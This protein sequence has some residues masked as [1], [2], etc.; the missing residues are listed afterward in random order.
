MEEE[1][2]CILKRSKD[3]YPETNITIIIV[4]LIRNLSICE[5]YLK[6]QYILS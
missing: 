4:L 1:V 6:K 3:I 2:E 5:N